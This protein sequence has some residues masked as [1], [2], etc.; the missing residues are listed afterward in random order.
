M[1]TRIRTRNFR[2]VQVVSRNHTWIA[3]NGATSNYVYPSLQFRKG[4]P[5][6]ET[7]DVEINNFHRRRADGELFFNPFLSKKSS[8]VV[9]QA[10]VY[11]SRRSTPLYPGESTSAWV[12]LAMT[13]DVLC[14]HG[15]VA[16]RYGYPVDEVYPPHVASLTERNASLVD[17]ASNK[18]LAK[19][20]ATDMSL[21]VFAA[22]L[23][24]TVALVGSVSSVILNRLRPI[25]DFLYNFS[26]N[27]YT[28]AELARIV[29]DLWLSWRYGVLPLVYD[30]EGVVK[31][32]T[33]P[34]DAPRLTA[35]GAETVQDSVLTSLMLPGNSAYAAITLSAETTMSYRVRA[36]YL[37]EPLIS[38]LSA[39]L[40]LHPSE[41]PTIIVEL[42]KLS[43]VADWF[44]NLSDTIRAMSYAVR[45]H[46]LG[47]SIVERF[48]FDTYYTST[49]S[50]PPAT[51]VNVGGVQKPVTWTLTTNQ[52]AKQAASLTITKR[53]PVGEPSLALPKVRVKLNATRVA[54]GL[55]LIAQALSGFS[56]H[57]SRIARI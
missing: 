22:E 40:G 29:S 4:G 38:G 47:G 27:R 19:I 12:K 32:L 43:F 54:D 31:A 46:V 10:G 16:S 1:Y 13:G 6:E 48:Q 57:S 3:S 20:Q 9:V 21:P 17:V 2:T 28:A 45:G 52:P 33:A 41:I 14:S 15:N 36:S 35:R 25:R 55:A 49:F 56:S 37:Y 51:T 30:L 23:H 34:D 50:D 26:K 7:S 53:T 18:A 44:V 24:Q 5:Y 8:A 11:E 42:T 39:R